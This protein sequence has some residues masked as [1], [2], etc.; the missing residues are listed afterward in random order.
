MM[1]LHFKAN[2]GS[3]LLTVG[4]FCIM[5]LGCVVVES[6][7]N[8]GLFIVPHGSGGVGVGHTAELSFEYVYLSILVLSF[9]LLVRVALQ[10]LLYFDTEVCMSNL[11]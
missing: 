5:I 6:P 11:K 2:N 7:H 9:S 8:A 1:P 4:S 3:I 10:I